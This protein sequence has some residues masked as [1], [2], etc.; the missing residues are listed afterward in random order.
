MAKVLWYHHP[1]MVEFSELLGPEKARR[2]AIGKIT[3][4]YFDPASQAVKFTIE[5]FESGLRLNG[6][7]PSGTDPSTGAFVSPRELE[8]KVSEI[9]NLTVYDNFGGLD[10]AKLTPE[11]LRNLRINLSMKNLNINVVERAAAPDTNSL[12]SRLWR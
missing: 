10:P 9:K 8:R 11:R 2:K 6:A 5:F 4:A 1:I 12:L 3:S 7:I